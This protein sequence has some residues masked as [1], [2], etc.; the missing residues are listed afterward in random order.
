MKTPEYE[1]AH[2][3]H[4]NW[5]F[6]SLRPSLGPPVRRCF[7]CKVTYEYADSESV[8]F[9]GVKEIAYMKTNRGRGAGELEGVDL[10]F[11]QAGPG[12]VRPRHPVRSAHPAQ[13]SCSVTIYQ[14]VCAEQQPRS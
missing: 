5:T 8:I 11:L 7:T 10:G 2:V 1:H 6:W 14:P 13:S 9:G 3:G 4:D 12:V